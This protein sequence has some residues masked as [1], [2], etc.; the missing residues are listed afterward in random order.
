MKLDVLNISGAKTGRTVELPAE[1]FGIEPNEHVV[2]LAVKQYLANQRQGTHKSKERS[3]IARS[4]RKLFKQKG[5]GGARRGDM[6]SPLVHGGGRVFGPRPRD[7][8]QK[9]NKKVRQLA[10][11]SVLSSKASAGAITIVEDFNIA[12]PKTKE[13]VNIL[14]NLNVTG[15][16]SLIVT[17]EYNLNIHHS[18][19][20]IVRSGVMVAGD[21]NTYTILNTQ[22]LILSESSIAKIVETF[23]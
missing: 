10:R 4:T 16:K 3:E 15:K 7:Y 13:F 20:N 8:S 1:V 12:T 23:A 6:K 19:R 2:Y 22:A 9:L 18:G 21:L 17:S 14:K 5:T 11:K